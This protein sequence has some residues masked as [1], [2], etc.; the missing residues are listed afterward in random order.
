MSFITRKGQALLLSAAAAVGTAFFTAGAFAQDAAVDTALVPFLVNVS[1]TV[2]AEPEEGEPVQMT[3]TAGTEAIL[4]LPI[5]GTVGV[6]HIV[7]QRQANSPAIVSNRG[8]KVTVNLPAEAYK[9]AELAL[10]T[11][12]GKRVL[13]QKISAASASNVITR[14]N[15]ATGAYLLSISGA[16]GNAVTSRLTHSGGGLEISA[17]FG[18]VGAGENARSDG[19]L[20][21]SAAADMDWEITVSAA[22]YKDSVF[23]LRPT[24]GTNA[25]QTI[26]LRLVSTG[27][28]GGG[29][30]N[31][32][33]DGTAGSC[34]TATIG[35][36]TWMAENLNYE[37]EDSWCYGEGGQVADYESYNGYKTLTAAEVQTNCAKYGRLYTWAAAKTACQSIGWR[38]SD[39]TDWKRM[40]ELYGAGSLEGAGGSIKLKSTSGWNDYCSESEN[41]TS[42]CNGTDDFGFSALPGGLRFDDGR[43]SGIGV[44]GYWWVDMEVGDR[45]LGLDI[46]T[47]VDYVDFGLNNRNIGY[48]VR[49]VRD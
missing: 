4:R 9:N 30:N 45:T 2:T 13:R 8:G 15:I 14:K 36:R 46:S 34:K 41:S 17:V 28:G 43:F 6:R 16:G 26:T 19:R 33:K 1:A 7:A 27:G 48:S 11:A 39:T 35:G 32:G 5:Y 29:D 22:G 37:T 42:I 44:I 25:R 23:T 40:A 24:V 18:G 31:C 38:L 21:K 49:C 20:A 10:Y 3:V 47:S 12:S